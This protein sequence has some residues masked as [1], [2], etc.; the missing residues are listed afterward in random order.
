M[1]REYRAPEVHFNKPWGFPV[2]IWSWGIIVG[3]TIRSQ[4]YQCGLLT[5][6]LCS[7]RNSL[8]L[9]SITNREGYMLS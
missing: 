1:R 7:S 9:M 5:P 4:F 3:S 8:S 2:H 6:D